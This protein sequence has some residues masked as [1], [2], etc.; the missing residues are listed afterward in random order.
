MH[1]WTDRGDDELNIQLRSPN[2]HTCT[3][4]Q[5]FLWDCRK[6]MCGNGNIVYVGTYVK[7]MKEI[8]KIKHIS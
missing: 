1:G 7:V 6:Y 8:Q 4:A 2:I 5:P 3:S